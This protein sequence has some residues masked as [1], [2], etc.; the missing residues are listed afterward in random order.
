[1]KWENV[2]RKTSVSSEETDVMTELIEIQH[3]ARIQD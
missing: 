2:L 1:M 3:I